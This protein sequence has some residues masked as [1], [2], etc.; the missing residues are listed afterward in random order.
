MLTT[1]FGV[2]LCTRISQE[3]ALTPYLQVNFYWATC[4]EVAELLKHRCRQGIW[5]QNEEKT[6]GRGDFHST[7]KNTLQCLAATIPGK[8]AAS[9]PSQY[10]ELCQETW[11]GSPHHPAAWVPL[12]RSVVVANVN[13]IPWHCMSKL[14]GKQQGL[15]LIR[16]SA[17]CLASVWLPALAKDLPSSEHPQM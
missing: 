4:S 6:A 10:L 7:R 11:P 15:S 5:S 3:G 16:S 17:V 12:L 9:Q 2:G 1:T 13:A 14:T 8:D